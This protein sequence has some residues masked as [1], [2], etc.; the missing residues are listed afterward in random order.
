LFVNGYTLFPAL[1]APCMNLMKLLKNSAFILFVLAIGCAPKIVCRNCA[2]TRNITAQYD[3]SRC[4][5]LPNG[6][7][8]CKDVVFSPQTIDV[9]K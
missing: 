5:D 4:R 1:V 9:R 6:K 8:I 7:Y 3:K 2:Y